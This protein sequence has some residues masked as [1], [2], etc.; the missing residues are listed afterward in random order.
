MLVTTEGIIL[1]TVKYGD[2]AYIVTLFTEDHGLISVSYRPGKIKGRAL[3]SP[4]S[5]VLLTTDIRAGK[6]IYTVKELSMALQYTSIPFSPEKALVVMFL[7]ELYIKILKE[8][9]PN[10]I[11]YR[12]LTHT[13]KELDAQNPLHP[14]YH[15]SVMLYLTMHLGFFPHE[16]TWQDDMVFDLRE[17]VFRRISD[18]HTDIADPEASRLLFDFLTFPFDQYQKVSYTREHRN[19]LLNTLI[20]YYHLH[21]AGFGVMKSVEILRSLYH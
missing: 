16:N 14:S 21:V 6:P 1:R 20:H 2:H 5:V 17:G 8:E 7:N 10:R 4:L 9:A 12:F 3:L 19:K 15:L 18:T 11:L 13:L